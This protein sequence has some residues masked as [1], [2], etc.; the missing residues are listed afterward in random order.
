MIIDAHQHYWQIAR[1]D[2]YWMQNNAAVEAIARDFLPDDLRQTREKLGIGKTVLVQAAPTTDETEFLLHLA[3]QE[4][5]VA[6][7]VGWIDFEDPS[8]IEFLRRWAT[9]PKFAGVRPMIQDIP[10]PRWMHRKDV[11]WAY[12]ALIELDL[13]FDAL[14][15]VEHL[16]PFDR[17]FRKYPSMRTVID[18][19]MKPR[20]R[21][22]EFNLWAD[23]M[24]RIADSDHVYCKCSG[25]MTEARPGDGADIVD[26][27]IEHLRSIFPDNRLMWGSDWPVMTLSTDYGAWLT[28]VENACGSASEQAGLFRDSAA[29]FYRIDVDTVA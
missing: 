19:G 23:A 6:R 25:L 3:E 21:D 18:H 20:I 13:T 5:S 7:V 4:D 9:H 24:S 27:Y 15:F 11:Q 26:R 16:E 28:L 10:D 17:L 2:Y 14:G 29:E 1:G 22:R 12:E 8:H